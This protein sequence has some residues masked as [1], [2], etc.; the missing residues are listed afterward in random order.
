MRQCHARPPNIFDKPEAGLGEGFSGRKH[1][2]DVGV[3]ADSGSC[4]AAT[5]SATR[6]PITALAAPIVS[7]L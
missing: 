2:Q 3:I 1:A 6:V 4:A 7:M 5:I